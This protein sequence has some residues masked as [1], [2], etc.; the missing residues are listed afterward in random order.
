MERKPFIT[1]HGEQEQFTAIEVELL[2]SLP[3]EKVE[4]RRS[5][6]RAKMIQVDVNFVPF[7]T[8]LLPHDDNIDHSRMLLQLPMLHVYFTDCPDNDAYRIVT[9]EKI[10]AWMNLLKE[11]NIVDWMIVLVEPANPRR[12]KPKLLPKHSVVDKIRNDFCGRQTERLVVLHEPNNPVPNNKSMESWASFVSRLRQLFVTAYNRTFSKYEDVVRAERERRVEKDWYFCSYF[13]LQEELALAFESMG[14]YEEAL[15][16]YDEL[17]ALF[18]QFIINSQAGENVNWLSAFT[19]TCTC[20]DGLNL[21]D[22]FNKEQRECIKNGKPS[23]LDLRNYLFSRQCALLFKMR[24]PSEVAYRSQSFMHT[25]VQE[26]S[27]LEVPMPPGS[28]A[29]WVFLTCVEVLQKYEKMSSM[30]QMEI[31]SHY[32]A[33]LWV[34]AQRKLAELGELCGLMPNRSGPS[35]EQLNSVVNLLSGM[36]KSSPATQNENSPNQKLRE[37]LS[38]SAAF[39]RHYLELSELAMGNFKHIGRLRSV[40]HIGK[41][42]ARFYQML[43][44]HQKAE[45]FL[46]DALRLFE[47]ERWALLVLDTRQQLAESQKELPDKEN[48]INTCCFLMGDVLLEKEKKMHFFQEMKETAEKISSNLQEDSN[49][50]EVIIPFQSSFGLS[51]ISILDAPITCSRN[52]EVKVEVDIFSRLPEPVTF[53]IVSLCFQEE[54]PIDPGSPVSRGSIKSISRTS[55]SRQKSQESGEFYIIKDLSSHSLR[56]ILP[57]IQGDVKYLENGTKPVAEVSCRNLGTYLRR[58]DSS[59]SWGKSKHG[60]IKEEFSES[61]D[62]SE[63]ELKPGPNVL[64]FVFKSKE[65]GVFRANQLV[66]EFLNGVSFVLNLDILGSMTIEVFSPEPQ[67]SVNLPDELYAG[68]PQDINI[69]ITTGFQLLKKGDYLPLLCSEGLIILP[70]ETE[71]YKVEKEENRYLLRF[72]E[73]VES[74]KEMVYPLT[75]LST[76]PINLE[77]G[78]N[79]EGINHIGQELELEVPCPWLETVTR[80]LHFSYPLAITHRCRTIKT[81]KLIQVSVTNVTEDCIQLSSVDLEVE[82]INSEDL[83]YIQ[84]PSPQVV[85]PRLTHSFVWFLPEVSISSCKSCLFGFSFRST[86][87]VS[88]STEPAE[89]Q[90]QYSF[91]VADLNTKYIISSSVKPADGKEMCSMGALCNLSIEIESVEGSVDRDKSILYEVETLGMW[92][93]CGKNKGAAVVASGSKV[94]TVQLEML[95]LVSGFLPLPGIKLSEYPQDLQPEGTP[96]SEIVTESTDDPADSESVKENSKP[97]NKQP[98]KELTLLPLNSNQVYYRSKAMQVQ[99]Y[100]ECNASTVEVSIS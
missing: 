47:K 38:S 69:T 43:G 45:T 2:Q 29:C 19:E 35:S 40:G 6:G 13:L 8:H 32:T 21:S 100:P 93:M 41:E 51:D 64:E 31:H 89:S 91:G 86:R 10:A 92:V 39:R 61:A 25:C 27:M 53:R 7:G 22:T 94:V 33:N 44:D 55:L 49:E 74:N 81:K 68:I 28:V 79:D 83:K 1:Y 63:V 67:L 77:E 50:K 72:L 5:F 57:D 59:T 73:D 90:L 11:R 46:E 4:W 88:L 98:Q 87:N 65:N 54:D 71:H 96:V 20:W 42:L 15:V 84:Q 76:I 60:L 26:L 78:G 62:L 14:I 23:L 24:K 99:V 36:G 34:Y 52:A 17:D 85:G 48:Y 82:D 66:I 37:A 30:C 12:S 9:K 97:V 56:D 3:R 80:A 95:P 18:T 58:Q 16:Q 75:V 70:T